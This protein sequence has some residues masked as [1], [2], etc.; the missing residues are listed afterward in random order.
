MI[1]NTVASSTMLSS[2]LRHAFGINRKV[3]LKAM[4]VPEIGIDDLQKEDR[5]EPDARGK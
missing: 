5:Q 3:K 1:T 2:H 4:V